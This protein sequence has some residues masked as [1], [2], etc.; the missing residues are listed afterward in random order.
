[1][2]VNLNTR[3]AQLTDF[4]YVMESAVMGKTCYENGLTGIEASV[5]VCSTFESIM[6]DYDWK[7]TGLLLLFKPVG[8]KNGYVQD[9]FLDK[10]YKLGTVGNLIN[11]ILGDPHVLIATLYEYFSGKAIHPETMTGKELRKRISKLD[12]PDDVMQ[13]FLEFSKRPMGIASGLKKFMNRIRR[14]IKNAYAENVDVIRNASK[15]TGIHLRHEGAGFLETPFKALPEDK[16]DLNSRTTVTVVYL[17]E[18]SIQRIE[19]EDST[20]VILGYRY[21]EALNAMGIDTSREDMERFLKSFSE[22]NRIAMI[23]MITENPMF[24]GEVSERT[25]LAISTTSYHLDMLMA[26]GVFDHKVIDKRA[27]YTM[28]SDYVADMFVKISEL[29]RKEEF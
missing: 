5:D 20:L 2:K 21:K 17:N 9:T 18:F 24:V 14:R 22:T 28:R 4:M 19:Q 3:V 16:R 7:T 13:E 15:V 6:N 1:M 27:Y 25:N 10:L 26:A 23:R 11:S 12:L 8:N 29:F